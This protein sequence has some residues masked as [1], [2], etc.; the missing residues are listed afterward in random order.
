MPVRARGEPPGSFAWSALLDPNRKRRDLNRGPKPILGLA[1]ERSN[2]Y[3]TP[4]VLPG[5][6]IGRAISHARQA[7]V[8]VEI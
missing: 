5:Q 1:G 3:A 4:H 6:T 7:V 8:T 2:H